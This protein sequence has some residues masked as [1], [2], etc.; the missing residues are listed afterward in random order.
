MSSSGL[1]ILIVLHFYYSFN[2]FSSFPLSEFLSS[3]CILL[4]RS[5]LLMNF[6]SHNVETRSKG[7]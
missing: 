6:A 1:Q 2:K 7:S 4:R 5:A 3:L